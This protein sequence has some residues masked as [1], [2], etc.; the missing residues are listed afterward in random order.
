VKADEA[1]AGFFRARASGKD[2]PHTT[3]AYRR[4]LEGVLKIL[5][6]QLG[7]TVGELEIE[8]IAPLPVMQ[9]AFGAFAATHANRSVLRAH[10]T[11]SMFFAHLLTAQV[12]TGSPMTG[13]RKP[14]RPGKQPKPLQEDT[15][16]RV[17]ET[18]RDGAVEWRDPWPERDAAVTL[19][20][21]RTGCRTA[22]LLGLNIVDVVR[23]PGE[24]A[25]RLFGKGGKERIFPVEGVLIG[26]LGVYL[27]SRRKRFPALALKRPREGANATPFDWWPPDAPLIVDREGNRMRSGAL[28]YL[29]G[30]VFDAAG[31][32]ADRSPGALAHVLR[33]TAANSYSR[34]GITAIELVKLFGW[35]SLATAQHYI[36]ASGSELR[37]AAGK[38]N[39]LDLLG[40]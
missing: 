32:G 15:L 31:V 10:S 9:D 38:S 36:D 16:A 7:T 14:A 27:D 5:A 2:S 4:D 28:K 1:V 30:K 8:Q 19:T 40:T 3:D 12:V 6:D 22:E 39:A 23:D 20:F 13:V 24:E 18:V 37:A 33:H 34:A 26:F 29:I 35:E 25:L 21:A 17:V 11:W